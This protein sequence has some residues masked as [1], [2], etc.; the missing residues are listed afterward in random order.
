MGGIEVVGP[1]TGTARFTVLGLLAIADERETAVLQPSKPA[2]LL[3]ALLVRPNT[4][5]SVEWLQ[6]AIWGEEIP[7][8]AKAALHSCVLR[9]RR[10]FA[11]YG[12]AGRTIEALPG[13]YRMV[14]DARSL[15]LLEF[16]ELL[17]RAEQAADRS[18]ELTL[19]RGALALWQLPVLGNVPS[20]ALHREEVPRLTEEWLRTA[21]RVYDIE[22]ALGR[23]REVLAELWSAARSHPVHERFWEQLI[24]ALYRTGRRADALAEYRRVRDHLSDELGVDPGPP[25]RRLELAILRGESV[26]DQPDDGR[27]RAVLVDQ[28]DRAE[29]V[30]QV[31][32][33]GAR[34]GP[35]GVPRTELSPELAALADPADPVDGATGDL[36]LTALVQAGLLRE[37]PRGQYRMHELLRSF[38]LAAAGSWADTP[39]AAACRSARLT[40][41]AELAELTELTGSSEPPEPIGPAV[42]DGT[43]TGTGTC[44]DA[45][46]SRSTRPS[47]A[48]LPSQEV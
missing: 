22:L 27:D 38:T 8:T 12:I 28:E 32:A 9:L 14:A 15:D 44:I 1:D 26:T 18:A 29:Q 45:D 2:T 11:R 37:G 46:H 21:E 16:R 41:P 25:L 48:P 31:T 4:V 36:V 6:W 7:T 20:D 24:E 39:V 30:A 35:R 43:G 33:P 34:G 40:K 13:G 42:P 10:L 19:L 17:V 5:V 23:C 3:A 47:A